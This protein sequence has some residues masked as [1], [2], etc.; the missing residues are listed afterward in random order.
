MAVVFTGPLCA[1]EGDQP[2]KGNFTVSS[3]LANE[4]PE[5]ELTVTASELKTGSDTD[6]LTG[7]ADF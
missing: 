1:L 7:V 6:T 5:H 4:Q 2:V 3:E